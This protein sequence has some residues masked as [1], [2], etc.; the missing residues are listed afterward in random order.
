MKFETIQR[1]LAH[2]REKGFPMVS[3]P[4]SH[5]VSGGFE[6]KTFIVPPGISMD[7]IDNRIAV[8]TGMRAE[9]IN[10]PEGFVFHQLLEDGKVWMSNIPV[11]TFTQIYP[12]MSAHG[13]VLVGGLGLGHI[14]SMMDAMA[15]RKINSIT[16]VERT[17]P[18]IDLVRPYLRTDIKVINQD[19][20][21]YLKSTTRR[22]D[23]IYLDTWAGSGEVTF[24][25]TVLPLRKLALNCLR[26]GRE[27]LVCWMEEVMR[28]RSMRNIYNT[29]ASDGMSPEID[30]RTRAAL[31]DP[32]FRKIDPV[33]Y[34]FTALHP[35]DGMVEMYKADPDGAG[36][37]IEEFVAAYEL[38]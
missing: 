35:F 13:D 18:I 20:A 22:F 21:A 36:R 7:V 31:T 4:Y 28:G 5:A 1:S 33:F 2:I 14:L 17:K 3:L 15:V 10:L 9:K 37:L 27:D 19:I 38:T 30:A 25:D 32:E 8:F 26:G 16:V 34:D 11:E 24:T 23:F 29:L 6:L 12:A